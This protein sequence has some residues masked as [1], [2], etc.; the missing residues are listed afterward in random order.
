MRYKSRAGFTLIE[1]LVAISILAIVAV[2]GWR[3]LDSIVRSRN[4]LNSELEETRSLQLTFAQ[5]QSDCSQAISLTLY[6]NLQGG[7]ALWID[8][9]QLIMMRTVNVEDQAPAVQVVTYRLD[10]GNLTR[11]ES[12]G[13][14][15]LTQL[16]QLVNAA[17]FP[18][19]QQSLI[20]MQKK[21][22]NLT[23]RGY[24]DLSFV[25][26]SDV[27]AAAV[28]G[29]AASASSPAGI[30]AP[31]QISSLVSNQSKTTTGLEVTLQLQGH[32]Q[33]MVK[34]FILGGA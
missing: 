22:A 4:A 8:S 31:P 1:L 13:T 10:N 2:L 25:A 7:R 15:D 20:V 24:P 9:Q 5:L 29:A 19:D 27:N 21:I 16:S 11:S 12:V 28:A 18:S 14:R 26:G 23:F 6:P 32:D 30:S 3:G 34:I 33:S 17:K